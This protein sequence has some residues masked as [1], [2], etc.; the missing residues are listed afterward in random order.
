MSAKA[1]TEPE[2]GESRGAVAKRL[3]AMLATWSM[4]AAA[5]IGRGL[6]WGATAT[7]RRREGVVAILGRVAWWGALVAWWSAAVSLLGGDLLDV[8]RARL[9]FVAGA[10]AC[11]MV[12][13][14]CRA[15]RLRWLGGALG[16]LHGVSAV[17]LWFVVHA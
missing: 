1:R 9:L 8:D 3:V 2:Q 6:A 10:V 12:V 13:V 5:T 4:A 16:S 7:W 14:S 17:V 15:G 11:A